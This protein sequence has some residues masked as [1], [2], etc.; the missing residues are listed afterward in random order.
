MALLS[1]AAHAQVA[2]LQTPPQ[3]LQRPAPVPVEPGVIPGPATPGG[4]AAPVGADKIPISPT[5]ITV[6]HNT[7]YSPADLEPL[8]A[9]LIGKKVTAADIFALAAAIQRKY[10]DDGYF[11]ATVVVPPQRVA[12]GRIRLRAYE[13]SIA[14]VVVDGDVGPV[15]EQARAYLAKIGRGGQAV[16]LRDVERYLLLTED[17][18][19]INAKAVLRPGKQPG[20][21]ELAVE[22]SRKAWDAYYALDNR[23]SR[24]TG[25]L[26]SFLLGG[27]SSFT[28]L[29]ERL[30][31]M[32]FTTFSGESNYFQVNGSFLV[33]SEGARIRAWAA[34]GFVNPS[35]PIAA[36]GYAGNLTLFGIGGMYPIIRTRQANL[37]VNG[38]FE[39]YRSLVDANTGRLNATH[40]RILRFGFDGSYRDDFNGA[41]TATIR[42]SKGLSI[43]GASAA[44]DPLMA[45]AGSDP[46]FFKVQAELARR[47]QIWAANNFVLG[48]VGS[49]SGQLTGDVLPA[50]EKFF[51]GGDRFGRG[52]Y[53]GEVS[54]DRGFAA[55]IELQ[56]NVLV[57]PG[58]VGWS[59]PASDLDPA[60]ALPLQFYAFFDYGRVWNLLASEAPA[61]TARSV[62]LGVRASLLEHIMLEIEL[63][64]RLDLR[65][66][67]AAATPLD[68]WA[69]FFKATTRF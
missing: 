43:L 30:E 42:F 47:Q 55:S 53:F 39:Y 17:I 52:Y 31:A 54:G 16:N 40:L 23:G 33:G 22:L 69:A 37:S 18:P 60:R 10:R 15:I 38:Q 2:P 66:D 11:L 58:G 8:I 28:S 64:R 1:G 34:K 56:L 63:V 26:Q 57:P 44:G 41:N 29:G 5:A 50:S 9:P 7:V 21:A 27:V 24:F 35:G 4:T 67:G 14:H 6:E 12:D 45:R 19:G 61:I 65:V 68:P 46:G 48:V 25:P 3:P 59:T 51:L 36:I 20:E 62:G 32:Q 13:G 49:L